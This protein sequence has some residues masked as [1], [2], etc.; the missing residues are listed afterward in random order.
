[1]ALQHSWTM[2]VLLIPGL[3]IKVEKIW[4]FPARA[5]D[6]WEISITTGSGLCTCCFGNA[7]PT[8]LLFARWEADVAYN[9]MEK[10]TSARAP[11]CPPSGLCGSKVLCCGWE[12]GA[13]Q[14]TL[15]LPGTECLPIIQSNER[16]PQS[17][18]RWSRF[19][20]SDLCNRS[21]PVMDWKSKPIRKPSDPNHSSVQMVREAVVFNVLHLSPETSL[22]AFEKVTIMPMQ[23]HYKWPALKGADIKMISWVLI[24]GKMKPL[25]LE[26]YGCYIFRQNTWRYGNGN[27]NKLILKR[28]WEEFQLLF[29]ALFRRT[30]QIPKCPCPED[31]SSVSQQE[32]H[33]TAHKFLGL[34]NWTE[35]T[36][37]MAVLRSSLP[38]HNTGNEVILGENLTKILF[39]S[40]P[41]WVHES[42]EQTDKARENVLKSLWKENTRCSKEGY[43]TMNIP[44]CGDKG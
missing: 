43:E 20:P 42:P 10:W 21:S 23:Q 13:L 15:L 19:L 22:A 17:L 41:L 38:T 39:F 5:R 36:T 25:T 8:T 33:G 24:L 44:Y 6:F 7:E 37:G 11:E 29:I 27:I 1:M 14:E 34:E 4:A 32:M 30:A 18:C 12:N 9:E 28:Q 35:G 16:E 40:Y 3:A 2:T 26:K 31:W